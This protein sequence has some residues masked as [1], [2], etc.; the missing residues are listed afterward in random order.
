MKLRYILI[1]LFIPAIAHAQSLLSLEDCI[2]LAKE[3]NKHISAADYNEQSAKYERRAAFANF[4]PTLSTEGLGAY[5]NASGA[6]GVEGG[7]LPAIG[8]DGI[9]TAAGAYFPGVNLN[10]EIGGLYNIGFKFQQPIFMGGKVIAVYKMGRIGEDIARQNRRLTETEVVVGTA[11]AYANVIQA[12]ELQQVAKSYNTLLNELMHSI[13]KAYERGM[14]SRNDV[15]KVEV[16]LDE[17]L[18]NLRRAENAIRLATM[19]LCHYIGRPLTDSIKINGELPSIDCS[20]VMTTDISA[21]PEVKM[22]AHKSELM[23]QKI[24]LARAELLPQIGLV[25][26]YG[27]LNGVKLGGNK[28][29][30]DWSFVAGVQISIPIINIGSHSRYQSAKMQ[31]QQT[32]SEEEATLELLTLEVTQ[33]ANNLEESVLEHSLAERGVA[34][35]TENLRVSNRQYEVGVEPLSDLLEAQTLWQQANQTLIEARINCFLCWIEYRKAV[36]LVEN[37]TR[38][39]NSGRGRPSARATPM[40]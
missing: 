16:K 38:N 36:G 26:Q 7:L 27:Y 20:L 19:N 5:S 37:D 34:S 6:F 22:L 15:L 2:A 32:K 30:D 13:E 10:Y 29:F 12:M 8:A 40:P 1:A 28:L 31:Y 9:P 11:R 24:N 23:H 4:F 14:K 35:A 25:G 21:R 18:L 39:Y 33:A 17:S 3:Y